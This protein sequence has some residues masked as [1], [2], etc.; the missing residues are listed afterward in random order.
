[1]YLTICLP[2]SSSSIFLKVI[3]QDNK[4]SIIIIMSIINPSK[5]ITTSQL[6]HEEDD[7]VHHHQLPINTTS[8]EPSLAA[9]SA[10]DSTVFS[11]DGDNDPTTGIISDEDDEEDDGNK[12]EGTTT[13]TTMEETTTT[14]ESESQENKEDEITI[15][16]RLISDGLYNKL[17]YQ[18]RCEIENEIHGV[19]SMG[20]L[21]LSEEEQEEQEEQEE[22]D[23]ADEADEGEQQRGYLNLAQ[24][25]LQEFANH[26]EYALLLDDVTADSDP[27]SS[28]SASGRITLTSVYE[29][30]LQRQYIYVTQYDSQ[31]KLMCLRADL[32]KNPQH[33]VVR[34]L[35][36]L[37]LLQKYYG[38]D[39]LQSSRLSLSS[40]LTSTSNSSTTDF[41]S[42]DNKRKRKFS[43]N[44][45]ELS[46][47]MAALKLGEFQLLQSKDRSGRRVVIFQEQQSQQH[48]SSASV[49]ASSSSK[50]IIQQQRQHDSRVS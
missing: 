18:E 26:L 27:S 38:S 5:A 19:Q 39:A 28:S 46:P 6:D 50:I 30:C 31:L 40:C 3:K 21:L 22:A 36:H 23:E 14:I 32:W 16:Q 20:I 13:A 35:N 47:E 2:L 44:H 8:E 1:V 4:S 7:S 48:A 34:F 43:T 12:E 49:S 9:A 10:T 45:K 41:S 33:S 37:N 15:L 25:A 11:S 17:S 29:I 24:N 42:H